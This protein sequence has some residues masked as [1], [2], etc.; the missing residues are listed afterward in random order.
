MATTVIGVVTDVEVRPGRSVDEPRAVYLPLAHRN[1]RSNVALVARSVTDAGPLADQLRTSLQHAVPD[2]GFLS[3]RTLEQEFYERTAP[4]PSLPRVFGVLGFIVFAVAIG[5][6][7]GLMSYLAAMRRREM[8]IRKALGATTL[9]LCRMLAH[10]SSRMLIAGVVIG[11]VG[12]LFLG[13]LW[14]RPG[15]TFRLLDPVAIFSVAGF[16]YLAGLVGAIAPFVRTMRARTVSLK[17]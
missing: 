17:D 1:R 15:S 16:L 6:L 10:E 11:I 5:G 4:P 2:T 14:I 9:A 8:G 7:Y 12:G 3:V 13:S